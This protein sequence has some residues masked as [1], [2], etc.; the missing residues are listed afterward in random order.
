MRPSQ[1]VPR[2]G[3]E[4]GGQLGEVTYFERPG[5][6]W[7]LILRPLGPCPPPGWEGEGGPLVTFSP[8]W[9]LTRLLPRLQLP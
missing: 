7:R 1:E 3:Q 9:G 8:T 6:A 5:L 2:P 4:G